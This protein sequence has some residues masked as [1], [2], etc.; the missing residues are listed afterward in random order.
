MKKYLPLILI[1]G[2]LL[3]I[4]IAVSVVMK[5]LKSGTDSSKVEEEEVIAELPASAWP[6]LSL[7]PIVDPAIPNSL[8]HVL[9]MDVK[10]I[11]VPDATSM[12]Y[13]LVYSTSNGGQQG[14]PGSVKLTGN[15][16]SKNLLLG[17]ESSGKYRF[18]TG[19]SEGTITLTFR[20]TNG[21]SLGKVESMFHLQSDTLELSSTDGKFMYTLDKAAKG[22]FFVTMPTLIEPTD[23]PNMVTWSNGYGVF[24]SDGKPHSGK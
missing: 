14:V 12:D 5:S 24:S 15:E 17:S 11:N 16:A 22:V 23:S 4:V 21:K 20:N 13:L 6:A 9:K 7:T 2:S 8:G 3:I 18:D 10:K 19:V 1:G